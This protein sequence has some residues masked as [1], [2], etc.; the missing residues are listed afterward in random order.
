MSKNP[1]I[2]AFLH[3]YW[4]VTW[5]WFLGLIAGMATL[6]LGLLTFYIN[7]GHRYLFFRDEDNGKFWPSGYRGA[8]QSFRLEYIIPVF[9]V[10]LILCL[11]L[12]V[13]SFKYHQFSK[14]L[15][16]IP[17]NLKK[18]IWYRIGHSF[19]MIVSV[20]LVQFLI[21][22]AGF[23]LYRNSAPPDLNI[24]IQLFMVFA[25]PGLFS[26]IYPIMTAEYLLLSI[27]GFLFF[28]LLPVFWS[29]AV[30]KVSTIKFV[31]AFI[32]WWILLIVY[33]FLRI[34]LFPNA[35]QIIDDV[36]VLI[37]IAL[38]LWGM[39]RSLFSQPIVRSNDHDALISYF[40]K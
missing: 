24:D 6:E 12:T 23:L 32:G 9:A 8:L 30:Q 40:K 25:H 11:V 18:Q 29:D 27:P 35:P 36:M 38:V 3:L 34:S 7:G 2:F 31:F 1:G 33:Y 22:I 13:N 14:F 19:I 10:I 21:L 15:I 28:I 16:R 37:M 26:F 4:K 17:V 20:W 5:K 39:I